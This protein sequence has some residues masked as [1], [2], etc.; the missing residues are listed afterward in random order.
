M[1]RG[2]GACGTR[3]RLPSPAGPAGRERGPWAADSV[4]GPACS[5]TTTYANNHYGGAAL[6]VPASDTHPV[7]GDALF[8]GPDIDGPYGNTAGEPRLD[9]ALGYAPT[10]GSVLIGRGAPITDNG[11][12]DFRGTALYQ[13]APD[14]GA[15][16]G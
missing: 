2:R 14:I 1:L 6:T 8:A 7:T 12:K 13:D 5:A 15:L 9:T 11:G 10:S 16:E 3:S 4:Q